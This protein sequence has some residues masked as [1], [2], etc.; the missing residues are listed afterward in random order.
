M[1]EKFYEKNTDKDILQIK[2]TYVEITMSL[3][4]K[5]L[6]NSSSPISIDKG[7]NK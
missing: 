1:T 5:D 4:E 2:D 6:K 7:K 3:S